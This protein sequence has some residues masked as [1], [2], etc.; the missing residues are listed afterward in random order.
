MTQA[1]AKYFIAKINLLPC[2]DKVNGKWWR[3]QKI[4]KTNE[5][6]QKIFIKVFLNL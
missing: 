1:N 5:K 3:E 2:D 6:L 4:K